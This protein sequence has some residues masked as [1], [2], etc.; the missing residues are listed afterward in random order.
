[1]KK[2]YYCTGDEVL[3]GD[4]IREGLNRNRMARVAVIIQPN[5][6]TAIQWGQMEGGVILEFTDGDR[7]L[8]QD[9]DEE[10]ELLERAT[11]TSQMQDEP[12]QP[13]ESAE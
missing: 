8:V 3:L 5:S 10:F 6:P 4:R 13:E 2:Y 9:F 11:D 7:W 12:T 1:M